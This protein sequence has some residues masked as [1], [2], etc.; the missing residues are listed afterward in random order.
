MLMPVCNT[1]SLGSSVS[2][3]SV[4]CVVKDVTKVLKKNAK[5]V[6]HNVAHKTPNGFFALHFACSQF[7]N[8]PV[9]I[10]NVFNNTMESCFK[11]HLNV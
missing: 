2:K 5:G 8:T 3:N 1:L 11:R 9:I 10:Q 4:F 6:L 7:R